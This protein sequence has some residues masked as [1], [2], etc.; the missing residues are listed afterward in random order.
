MNRGEKFC[1]KGGSLGNDREKRSQQHWEQNFPVWRHSYIRLRY[2]SVNRDLFQQRESLPLL[3]LTLAHS[4]T[5]SSAGAC[6]VFI[7]SAAVLKNEVCKIRQKSLNFKHEHVMRIYVMGEAVTYNWMK[8][9]TI[10]FLAPVFL[11]QLTQLFSVRC[12]VSF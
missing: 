2:T 6:D 1:S 11:T 7:S 5:C 4:L 12:G 10:Y 9:C 3:V 8:A